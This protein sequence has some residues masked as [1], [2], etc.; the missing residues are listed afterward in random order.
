MNLDILQKGNTCTLRLKGRLTLG[1]AV[2]EFDQAVKSS[3]TGD[4][5]HLVLN[6]ESL[7]YIDSSGIG[8]LVNT[9]QESRAA[10]GDT[11]LVNPS[12]FVTKMLKMVHLLKL[13]QVYDSETVALGALQTAS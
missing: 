4:H 11:V 2:N 1:D 5:R 9:L 6:L 12:P 3:L 13:F 7:D 8:A 10:G